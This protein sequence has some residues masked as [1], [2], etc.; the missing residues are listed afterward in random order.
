[1]PISNKP[2][3]IEDY[4]DKLPNIFLRKEHGNWVKKVDNGDTSLSVSKDKEI[5]S[6]KIKYIMKHWV[7]KRMFRINMDN[8]QVEVTEDHSIIV[9]RDE[10]ILS[11][12]PLEMI[13]T[14]KILFI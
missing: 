11:V 13:K 12:K 4:Y 2:I 5:E 9:L 8:K 6:K 7:K 10:E 1:M 14:D 3:T